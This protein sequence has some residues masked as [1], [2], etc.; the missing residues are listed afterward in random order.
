MADKKQDLPAMPLYIGDWKKDPVIQAMNE[1]DEGIF[2]RLIMICWESENRG[3]LQIN[4][5]PIPQEILS[6]MIK[7]DNQRLT[8]W[9]SLYQ[10]TFHIFG[11]TSDGILYSRKHIKLLELSEKRK[12]AGKQG[13]NP[14]LLKEG[15]TKKQPKGYPLGKPNTENE[16]I[17]EN[18]NDLKKTK[19]QAKI[20][21]KPTASEVTEYAKTI[22]FT[23]DGNYFIDYYN[24]NGWMVGKNKMKDWKATVRTWKNRNNGNTESKTVFTYAEVMELTNKTFDGY[25]CFD[26]EKKLWRKK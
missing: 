13:G 19:R 25:E 3:Y 20:F 1:S 6:K 21:V 5:K 22:S 4:G 11:E 18:I 17:N 9:L 2:L 7:L 15:L 14:K 23:L 10:N 24:S 8:D 26:K 12:M 16:N